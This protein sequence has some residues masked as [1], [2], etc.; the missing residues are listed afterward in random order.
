MSDDFTLE[1]LREMLL[2]KEQPVGFDEFI[3]LMAEF[4]G[5]KDIY[6][7]SEKLIEGLYEMFD[8]AVKYN[9]IKTIVRKK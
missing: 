7:A 3:L 4:I 5:D 6:K 8:E 1:H 2:D 9:E